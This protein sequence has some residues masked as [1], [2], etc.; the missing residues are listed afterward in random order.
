MEA[1]ALAEVVLAEDV[2]GD[3]VGSV[4]RI[5]PSGNGEIVV[6]PMEKFVVGSLKP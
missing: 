6:A 3:V 4:V 5:N 2:A 1:A